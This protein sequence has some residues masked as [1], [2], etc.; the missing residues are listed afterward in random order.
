MILISDINT[1]PNVHI[2][3]SL[4]YNVKMPS[5]NWWIDFNIHTFFLQ[6]VPGSPGSPGRDG[7]LGVRV[8]Y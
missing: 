5:F 2:I 3:L 8:R 1:G 4:L 6:G 7:P